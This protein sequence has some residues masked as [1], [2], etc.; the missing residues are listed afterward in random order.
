[1][2]IDQPL[3]EKEALEKMDKNNF[4][5]LDATRILIY[6]SRPF[7]M[8]DGTKE[9]TIDEGEVILKKLSGILKNAPRPNL[10][11]QLDK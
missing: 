4:L 3:K 2:I 8:T 9:L 7:G 11:T 10:N 5:S 1:M 6:L